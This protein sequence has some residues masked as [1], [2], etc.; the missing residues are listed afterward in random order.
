M[1]CSEISFFF[2]HVKDSFLVAFLSC[3]VDPSLLFRVQPVP[4][5]VS[6]LCSI[7]LLL[8]R[9][10]SLPCRLRFPSCTVRFSSAT[11]R[12]TSVPKIWLLVVQGSATVSYLS[13]RVWLF[14]CTIRLRL[15]RIRFLSCMV[16]LLLCNFRFLWRG[17]VPDTHSSI[18][19]V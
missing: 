12:L 5:T 19:V 7:R 16:R 9:I 10:R 15:R 8:R 2:F 4:C 14:P 1:G 17:S 6:N 11:V 13:Y 3:T 18:L